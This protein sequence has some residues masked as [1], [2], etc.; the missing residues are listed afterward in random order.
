MSLMR[1]TRQAI[2]SLKKL[3]P[4]SGAPTKPSPRT[5]TMRK[6]K[7]VSEPT[8]TASTL[9]IKDVSIRTVQH[10]LQRDLDLPTRRNL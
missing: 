4:Y 6:P 3:L 8:L 9:R 10:R 2:Y 7:V 5:D 1:A